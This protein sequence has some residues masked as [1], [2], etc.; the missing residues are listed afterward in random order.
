MIAREA[1]N[2]VPRVQL[3]TSRIKSPIWF[4]I[5]ATRLGR[6]DISGERLLGLGF[7]LLSYQLIDWFVKRKALHLCF[8]DYNTLGEITPTKLELSKSRI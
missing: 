6:L 7:N 2:I 5:P 8:L 1:V 4:V 3:E